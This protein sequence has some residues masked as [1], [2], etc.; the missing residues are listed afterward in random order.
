MRVFS[1]RRACALCAS[2]LS[3]L[4]L[5]ASAAATSSQTE[6]DAATA[7]AAAYV[8]SQQD[9]V[10]G[11]ILGF[12]GEWAVT[13]LTAAGVD[14]A[15]LRGA[16]GGPS[17]QDYLLGNYT[18]AEWAGPPTLGTSPYERGILAAH[19][20]GLDPARLSSEVNLPAQLAGLWNPATGSFGTPGTNASAFGVFALRTTPAPLWALEPTVSFLRRTQ[21]DDG[22]WTWSGSATAGS[23]AQPSETDMTGSVLAALCEAGVP[24]YDPDLAEALTYLR[25]E[26]VDATGA[27]EYVWG[28]PNADVNAWVLSGL[29]ACGI[30][31]QSAAWTTSAGKT[32]IDYLLSQ[33]EAGG[34]FTYEGSGSL[35]TTQGALRAI[36]G[37]VFTATPATRRTPPVVGA[38]TPVPHALAIRF[39]PG[40]VRMCKVTAPAGAPLTAVLAAAREESSPAGCLRSFEVS[41]GAVSAIDGVSPAGSDES[42]LARLDRG[43]AAVAGSQPVGFGD[44]VSLWIGSTPSSGQTVVGQVGP[45]GVPGRAGSPGKRGKRGPKGRPGRNATLVCKVRKRRAGGKATRCHVKRAPAGKPAGRTPTKR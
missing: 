38:G 35:Y 27:F 17:L 11:G 25:G 21:H 41:S 14:A 19:A 30:D 28:E 23:K 8:A 24:T 32:A 33:Q 36:A 3:L 18:E 10:S 6:I 4:V 15:Q 9:A 16:P 40:N 34:A 26:M 37:G 44:F 45:A 20:A 22:G 31:P 42:W 43:A 29:N 1:I 39:G 5:P 12:G 2:L 13:A 7:K